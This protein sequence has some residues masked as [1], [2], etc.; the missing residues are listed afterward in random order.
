MQSLG[1]SPASNSVCRRQVAQRRN[2][3]A[4][5]NNNIVIIIIISLNPYPSNSD[6]RDRQISSFLTSITIDIER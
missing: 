2:T 6:V 5:N 4:N 1:K 3:Q